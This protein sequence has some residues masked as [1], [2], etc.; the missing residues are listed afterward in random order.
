MKN[1]QNIYVT[2]HEEGVFCTEKDIKQTQVDNKDF[3][4]YIWNDVILVSSKYS[5]TV[6]RI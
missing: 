1:Q 6:Y 5:Q 3:Q 2:E 4:L